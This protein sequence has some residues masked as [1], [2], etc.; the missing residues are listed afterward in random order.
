[1]VVYRAI[2]CHSIYRAVF[3]LPSF[4]AYTIITVMWFMT[5]PVRNGSDNQRCRCDLRAGVTAIW[6]EPPVAQ[7][8]Q[9]FE[10]NLSITNAMQD[11]K[12]IKNCLTIGGAH[13]IFR[14]S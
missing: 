4:S 14:A 5:S 13:A 8:Y 6:T 2:K 7:T 1:M 10:T 3:L 9:N 12:P 11:E